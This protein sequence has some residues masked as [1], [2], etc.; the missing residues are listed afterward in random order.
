MLDKIR[1]IE[2][3]NRIAELKSFARAADCLG[4]SHPVA[5]RL[6][7]ELEKELGVQL[8]HRT[9]RSVSLTSEG[10]Q[11][12]EKSLKIEELT[13]SLFS[14]SPLSGNFLQG[15]IRVGCSGSFARFYSLDAITRFLSEHKEVQ[16]ELIIVDGE[17][18]LSEQRLDIAFQTGGQIN[19]N[20]IAHRLGQCKSVLCAS[21]KYLQL[22]GTPLVPEDLTNHQLLSNLHLSK[23]W[24]LTK[25]NV[26][27]EI[28]AEGV[29]ACNNASIIMDAV[30]R[31]LGIAL[32]P[33]LALTHLP[34]ESRP[35]VLLSD[36][37]FPLTD[38]M[39][40]VDH[41]YL[42]QVVKALLE[43]VKKDLASVQN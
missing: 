35:I 41:R 6:I 36:W 14:D 20:Y 9:T 29:F 5:S 42:P 13:N 37:H 30:N 28:S 18:K 40:L 12:L 15:K 32:L 11:F 24:T 22:H 34:K 43:F 27:K 4:L 39:A 26:V 1:A 8:L 23:N 17:I 10:A 16:I 25:N 19:P 7:S 38:I 2:L 33:D 31:H 21:K 3:F